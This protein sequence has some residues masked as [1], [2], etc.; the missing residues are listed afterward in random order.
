MGEES[1]LE[2]T[3]PAVTRIPDMQNKDK[4]WAVRLEVA[5][6]TDPNRLHEMLAADASF[7]VR[8][9]VRCIYISRFAVRWRAI[10]VGFMR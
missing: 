5:E 1:H 6:K 4:D 3:F 8:F 2:L 9:E 10:P 7:E